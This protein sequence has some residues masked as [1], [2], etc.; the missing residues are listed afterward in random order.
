VYY[1]RVYGNESGRGTVVYK[2]LTPYTVQ[3]GGVC[4]VVVTGSEKQI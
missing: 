3:N 1:A 4:D 2:I